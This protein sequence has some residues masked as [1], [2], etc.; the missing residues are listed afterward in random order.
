M[1]AYDRFGLVPAAVTA[2]YGEFAA[3]GLLESGTLRVDI[4]DR[5]WGELIIDTAAIKM[6]RQ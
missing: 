4:L 5:V 2:R 1:V 6:C 3:F